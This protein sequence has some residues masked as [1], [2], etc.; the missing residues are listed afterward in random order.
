[1]IQKEGGSRKTWKKRFLRVEASELSYYVKSDC[2][3]KKGVIKVNT[4]TAINRV[5][6]YKGKQYIVAV[7][8]NVEKNR[9]YFIQG[10]DENEADKWVKAIEAATGLI[11]GSIIE[12]EKAIKRSSEKPKKDK[13]SKAKKVEKAVV[14]KLCELE[15]KK[16]KDTGMAEID[17][18]FNSCGEVM[19]TIVELTEACE[20]ANEGLLMLCEAK[21]LGDQEIQDKSVEG[22]LKYFVMECKTKNIEV[23]IG[24]SDFVIDLTLSSY[25]DS[26]IVFLFN[27]INNLVQALNTFVIEMPPLIPKVAEFVAQ[28]AD[29]EQKVENGVTNINPLKAPIALKNTALNL[30]NL[31]GIPK[32]LKIAFDAIIAL[33][34]TIYAIC[35]DNQ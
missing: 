5:Q 13:E 20:Q 26:V 18:W 4:I 32:T 25:E 8:T 16:F 27:G 21:E 6:N 31:A 33:S 19:D 3:E 12:D 35:K 30:K 1:M 34:K 15:Y 28:S 22:I 14:K 24:F 17:D 9:T 29:I 11:C 2:K 10:S 23:S 7:A